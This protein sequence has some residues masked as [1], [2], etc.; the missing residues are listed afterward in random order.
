M[1]HDIWRKT[2]GTGD[3]GT[4]RAKPSSKGTRSCLF[5]EPRPKLPMMMTECVRGTVWKV[6]R[7]MRG[8]E[9]VLRG[10]KM[11]MCIYM[12]I[13]VYVYTYMYKYI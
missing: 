9:S 5:V 6:V 11:E 1:S 3:L 12:H 10:K 7:G 2:D 8:K 13:C 4:E